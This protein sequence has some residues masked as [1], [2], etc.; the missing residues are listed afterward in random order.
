MQREMAMDQRVTA[1][2]E[3]LRQ[4]AGEVRQLHL[5]QLFEDDAGR[6]DRFTAQ[7]CGILMD[8]SKA[9]ITPETMPK[10][11]A[12]A[13]AAGIEARR[14]A[15]FRARR[16]TPPRTG[17]SCIPPCATAAAIPCWWTART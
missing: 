2:F 6:F 12:L 7:A 8:Y 1:A 10:L 15:M 14:D 3:A 13:E 9:R 17:R 5:R 11:V 16:S 4:H